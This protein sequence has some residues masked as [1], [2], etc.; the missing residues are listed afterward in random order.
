MYYLA[1]GPGDVEAVY[2]LDRS[3]PTLLFLDD[4]ASLVPTRRAR[5]EI[6]RLAGEILIEKNKLDEDALVDSGTATALAL[7]ESAE[8][9]MSITEL[10]DAVGAEVVV[11]A[12]VTAFE[13]QAGRTDT[14]RATS[15]LQ[16]MIIDV[17]TGD[18]LWPEEMTSGVSARRGESMSVSLPLRG[19]VAIGLGREESRRIEMELAQKTGTAIAELFYN[20]EIPLSSR[21]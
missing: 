13:V 16:I 9:P 10:G 20:V 21:R 15:T 3:R 17:T 6:M 7:R 18:L 4:P 1:A 8:Q 12:A 19:T 14:G 2:T 11:Y 5:A